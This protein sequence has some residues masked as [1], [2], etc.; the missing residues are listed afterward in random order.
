VN[1]KE[2]FRRRFKVLA[3]RIF[4]KK[5]AAGALAALADDIVLY[6]PFW[7]SPWSNEVSP[8]YGK[9]LSQL[10]TRCAAIARWLSRMDDKLFRLRTQEA[11][12]ERALQPKGLKL[13]SFTI[14]SVRA[15]AAAKGD[16]RGSALDTIFS[17]RLEA[18]KSPQCLVAL[19]EWRRLLR[20]AALC[21]YDFEH[22]LAKVRKGD[23]H[24]RPA[25]AR[26]VSRDID[27]LRFLLQGF[28][29][30]D[31]AEL[32]L[33]ELAT[34]QGASRE[35][36]KAIHGAF[37]AIS[38][39]LQGP[40]AAD[41]LAAVLRSSAED[42]ELK[43]KAWKEEPDFRKAI[44]DGLAA[45]Y[46]KRRLEFA[47]A[48]AKSRLAAAR[49]RLF[50]EL[51]LFEVELYD[52]ERSRLFVS[53]GLGGFRRIY[54]LAALKTFARARWENLVRIPVA[55]MLAK[56]V[57]AEAEARFGENLSTAFSS[58][59][60]AF[61]KLAD[62]ERGLV[63]PDRSPM[64]AALKYLQERSP[65]PVLKRRAQKAG[66][67]LDARAEEVLADTVTAVSAL[68]ASLAKLVLDLRSAEPILAA[69]GKSLAADH[70][71][72]VKSIDTARAV[73]RALS[74]LLAAVPPCA[75]LEQSAE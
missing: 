33:I 75:P 56:I 64:P 7:Y 68:H 58:L 1:A 70:A 29:C 15:E 36:L 4:K 49:R 39:L 25:D 44:V 18:F 74:E 2:Y 8:A 3:A 71:A 13:E 20:L 34:F 12:M 23:K 17:A 55:E 5:G 53:R 54:S 40:F 46:K 38:S 28:E 66:F 27:D 22:A 35:D 63:S 67:E 45:E 30:D 73:L 19:A 37:K 59:V 69:N 6:G 43:L 50:G 16:E 41:R 14:E 26:E 51:K 42:P 47:E 72:L 61:R 57:W 9:Q 21:R 10:L 32:G 48:Q 62:F 31:T 60:E 24:W 65:D 52:E 11:L